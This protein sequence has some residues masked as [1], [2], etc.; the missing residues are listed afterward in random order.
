M[1]I[2]ESKDSTPSIAS[3]RVF[4]AAECSSTFSTGDGRKGTRCDVDSA[5]RKK[6]VEKKCWRRPLESRDR[7]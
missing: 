5:V 7:S 2:R 4:A 1:F 3:R 6:A